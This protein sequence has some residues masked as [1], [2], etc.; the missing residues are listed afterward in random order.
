MW[1]CYTPTAHVSRHFT[2]CLIFCYMTVTA[3]EESNPARP[4]Y[5]FV[6]AGDD[7]PE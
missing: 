6:E 5:G 3:F 7:E 4:Y 2:I 1:K